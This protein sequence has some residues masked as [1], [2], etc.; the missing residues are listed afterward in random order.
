MPW[1][2]SLL[3]I[4]MI[5][6]VL[7]AALAGH[8]KG[9]AAYNLSDFETAKAE[10]LR[11]ATVG[12]SRSQYMLGRIYERGL[13]VN[14]NPITAM[15]WYR[16]S[17]GQGHAIAQYTLAMM[18]QKGLLD[19]ASRPRSRSMGVGGIAASPSQRLGIAYVEA[20]KW[21][22]LAAEQG[23]ADAQYNLGLMYATGNGIPINF[24][25]AHLWWSVAVDF[26]SEEAR[27]KLVFLERL[28]SD[29]DLGKARSLAVEWRDN[30]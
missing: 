5:F 19:S 8:D 20:L 4:P 10:F 7:N 25:T 3:T 22:E 18:H 15:K 24:V 13:G 11:A 2:R 17:A 27:R 23:V 21:F 14:R 26:G 1:R 16:L 12:D 29:S 9:I 30:R 28:M 6:W